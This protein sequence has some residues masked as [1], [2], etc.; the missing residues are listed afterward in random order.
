MRA[1]L[2]ILSVLAVIVLS[3]SVAAAVALPSVCPSGFHEPRKPGIACISDGKH[4]APSSGVMIPN[5]AMLEKDPQIALR[6]KIAAA[7]LGLGAGLLVLAALGT[8][9]RRSPASIDPVVATA[10]D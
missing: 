1:R 8:R 2:V 7:G 9:P 4:R 5:A 10:L 6:I 3:G